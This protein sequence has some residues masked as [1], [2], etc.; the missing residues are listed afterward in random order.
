VV[1]CR[2]LIGAEIQ[3]IRGDIIRTSPKSAKKGVVT[4]FFGSRTQ[5]FGL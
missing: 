2:N 3:S 4:F 5:N 1:V